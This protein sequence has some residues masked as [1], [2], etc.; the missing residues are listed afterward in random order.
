[1]RTVTF[2]RAAEL[3]WHGD[4][5]HGKGN[6]RAASD[7]FD[8]AATF[9]TVRGDARGSTTPEELLAAAHAVCFGIGLRSVIGRHGASGS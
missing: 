7:A 2:S 3:E 4:V 9:P 6:V 5:L 1:M 8:V